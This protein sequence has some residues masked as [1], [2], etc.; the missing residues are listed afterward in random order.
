MLFAPNRV[1]Y[2]LQ[3]GTFRFSRF[4]CFL[5]VSAKLQSSPL[6]ERMRRRKCSRIRDAGNVRKL[7][8]HSYLAKFVFFWQSDIS[9]KKVETK[10][11]LLVQRT[12]RSRSAGFAPPFAA[13]ERSKTSLF[14]QTAPL[15]SFG[16]KLVFR[17]DTQ[18]ILLVHWIM[19][20]GG[21]APEISGP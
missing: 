7:S 20:L 19:G 8:G 9:W 12:R 2:S 15:D 4:C 11:Y 10:R 18:K 5:A 6:L 3:T 1:T 16:Q 17:L 13:R 14:S 21:R